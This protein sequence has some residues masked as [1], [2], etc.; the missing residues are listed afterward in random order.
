MPDAME[1]LKIVLMSILAAAIYGI[2]HDQVTARVCVEYF[3][4]GH[5]PLFNTNSPTLLALGWGVIASWWMGAFLG[6]PLAAASRIGKRPKLVASDL[7]RPVLTLLAVMGFCALLAGLIGY[8]AASHGRI[9]LVGPMRQRVPSDRHVAFLSDFCAHNTAY[10]VGFVGGFVLC[11]Y[12]VYIRN[13]RAVAD[14][15][16]RPTHDQRPPTH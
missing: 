9:S 8:S 4:I 3:T 13:Q 7:L 14:S 12:A 15:D 2:C 11:G 10:A 16:G 5:A 6:I 1:S